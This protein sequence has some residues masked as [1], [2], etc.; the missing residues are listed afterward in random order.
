MNPKMQSDL[1]D[2]CY[3]VLSSNS[4]YDYLMRFNLL[5]SIIFSE[6]QSKINHKSHLPF[7][8][9]TYIDEYNDVLNEITCK[10][11]KEKL[12]ENVEFQEDIFMV[13]LKDSF[14]EEYKMWEYQQETIFN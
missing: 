4:E 13:V 1:E 11:N 8:T 7:F 5:L 3:F 9:P 2:L 6:F 12:F 14:A 10:L